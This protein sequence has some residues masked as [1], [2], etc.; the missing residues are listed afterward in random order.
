M[1]LGIAHH[2]LVGGGFLFYF[3]IEE[4]TIL[5]QAVVNFL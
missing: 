4:I 3:F 5:K 1:S 2:I